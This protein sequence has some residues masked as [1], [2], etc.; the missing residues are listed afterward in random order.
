MHLSLG[1]PPQLSSPT[2]SPGALTSSIVCKVS[3]AGTDPSLSTATI[4]GIE[5]NFRFCQHQY[6][7]V[8]IC[9]GP[10]EVFILTVNASD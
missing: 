6:S 2:R 3:V 4:T 5:S 9:R 7:R 1:T 10:K 8:R